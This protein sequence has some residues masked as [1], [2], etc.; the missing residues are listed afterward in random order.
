[1]KARLGA[2]APVAPGR[3]A[4]GSLIHAGGAAVA[5]HRSDD[6]VNLRRVNGQ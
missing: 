5:L 3:R 1:M 2:M 4:E 6:R